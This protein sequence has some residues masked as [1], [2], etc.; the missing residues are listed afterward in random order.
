M[1][2]LLKEAKFYRILDIK[3][4]KLQCNLCP[5]NCLLELEKVGRCKTRKN[6]EGKLY[7]LTYGIISSISMDPIEKKPLYHYYPGKMILSVGSFGCNFK[8]GFCQNWEISQIEMTDYFYRH[9]KI[10]P[11]ELVKIALNQKDNI[12]IGI[13]Y[14]YNE[15]LINYEFILEIAENIK[16]KNMKNVIVSNGYIN[17]EPLLELISYID[18]ANID[19]KSFNKDFYSKVCGGNLKV[20]LN[21]IE[22]FLKYN[23]HIEIT[24]LIIPSCNDSIKEIKQIVDYISS[25]SVNIPLH[26]TKYYPMYNFDIIETPTDTLI[27]AYKIAKEKLNYVY[28]GNILDEEYSSTYCKSCNKKIIE[29]KGYYTKI[30]GLRDNSDICKFC[31]E[32]INI[33]I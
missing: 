25:L 10:S 19:L 29:R 21:T 2:N 33:K 15:P 17:K 27:N 32:H 14:T 4:K 30:L 23:K 12:N 6:I 28:I 24:T 9:K 3:T 13:A 5:H 22:I 20:V 8:C 18:A 16:N 11:E 7:S 26:F 1:H 31:G